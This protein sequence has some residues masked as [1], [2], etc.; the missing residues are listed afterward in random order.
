MTKGVIAG[1]PDGTFKP[2]N[3]MT[4]QGLAVLT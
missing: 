1:F 4:R 3:N 2:E